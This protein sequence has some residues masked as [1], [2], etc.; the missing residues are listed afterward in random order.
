MKW[1]VLLV[2]AAC[3]NGHDAGPDAS[4][5]RDARALTHDSTMVPVRCAECTQ[6]HT[7]GTAL[8]DVASDG[9]TIYV[10]SSDGTISSVAA[11]GSLAMIASPTMGMIS[12]PGGVAYVTASSS[13]LQV[14][15]LVGSTDRLLG[16][17]AG[18]ITSARRFVAGTATDVYVLGAGGSLWRFSRATTN[19]APVVV[20]TA[21]PGVGLVV[22]SCVLS[23]EVASG[24]A[25]RRAGDGHSGSEP[26]RARHPLDVVVQ[27]RPRR[28]ARQD[29]RSRGRHGRRAHALTL[30]A[31]E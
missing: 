11:D 7:T 10:R 14:H 22:G 24:S 17:V 6:I 5:A 23:P 15:E 25:F 16:S 9:A 21:S 3:G 28:H 2:L 8:V 20:A 29:L 18:T 30:I 12:I 19:T 27:Q 13:T 26:R 4:T 1:P 31:T